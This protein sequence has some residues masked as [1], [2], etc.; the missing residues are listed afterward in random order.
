MLLWVKGIKKFWTV[1]SQCHKGAAGRK[2]PS[3]FKITFQ[4]YASNFMFV[5]IWTQSSLF[6]SFE[7][8]FTIR[9]RFSFTFSA[10]VRTFIVFCWAKVIHI[11]EYIWKR[12]AACKSHQIAE[13]YIQALIALYWKIAI[14]HVENKIKLRVT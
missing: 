11:S 9:F 3:K 2:N 4:M 10:K 8:L 7:L 14:I 12:K 5:Y 13:Q 6:V 1:S